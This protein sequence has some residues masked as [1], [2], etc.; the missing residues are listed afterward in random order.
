MLLLG[1]VIEGGG[2][3]SLKGPSLSST[4][5]VYDGG[6]TSRG[7]MYRLPWRVAVRLLPVGVVKIFVAGVWE[8]VKV[9]PRMEVRDKSPIRGGNKASPPRIRNRTGCEVM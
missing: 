9:S 8:M 7:I 4:I 2:E 5:R 3:E 1:V 6:I